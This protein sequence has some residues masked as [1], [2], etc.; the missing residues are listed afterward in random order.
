[1]EFHQLGR[2]AVIGRFDGGKISSDAGGVLLRE[3]EPWSI[4]F[5]ALSDYSGLLIKFPVHT[6]TVCLRD[7]VYL[8]PFWLRR[9][10]FPLSTKC[11]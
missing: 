8:R 11:E 10:H 7:R 9:P 2:R 5:T 1:M 3:V 4:C 6:F